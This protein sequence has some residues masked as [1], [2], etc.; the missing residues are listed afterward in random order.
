MPKGSTKKKANDKLREIEDQVRRG[1]YL[2]AKEI[3]T[4][5]KV[6]KDWLAYKKLNVRE[7]TYEPIRDIARCSPWPSCQGRGKGRFWG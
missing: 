2:P 1:I 4:F 5:G 3:P 7:S 6:A